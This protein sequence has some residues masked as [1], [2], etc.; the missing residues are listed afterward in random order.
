MTNAI[1]LNAIFFIRLDYFYFFQVAIHSIRDANCIIC[2]TYYDVRILIP[3]FCKMG[4]PLLLSSSRA[5]TDRRT[6]S[7][8]RQAEAADR[9]AEAGAGGR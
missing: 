6:D 9:E 3:P 5:D 8:S 4:K 1:L 2:S 7:S